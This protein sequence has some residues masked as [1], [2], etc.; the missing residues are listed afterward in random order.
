M[1]HPA[2][3]LVPLVLSS[4]LVISGVAKLRTSSSVVDVLAALGV[5]ARLGRRL[6]PALP[7][8]EIGAAVALVVAPKGRLVVVVAA[9]VGVLFLAYAVVIVRLWRH[10]GRVRCACFGSLSGGDVTG[11]T[12]VRNLLLAAGA[13]LVL[14]GATRGRSVAAELAAASAHTWTWLA[15]ATWA[16]GVAA[17]L[18]LRAAPSEDYAR[19]PIPRGELVTPSGQ[20]LT[21]GELASDQARLLIFL[22]PGCGPC[23]DIS[24]MVQSWSKRLWPIV[25]HPVLIDTAAA[26]SEYAHLTPWWLFADGADTAAPALGIGATPAAVVLG[27]D[28]FLAGGPVAGSAAVCALVEEAAAAVAR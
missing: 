25:V 15:A 19:A 11:V 10:Q 16:T 6:D 27:S 20:H 18:G 7:W 24:M 14:L 3:L 26:R 1:S 5:P 12:V 9:L 2:W 8:I 21:L 13:V 17:S 23:H 28:G 22:S 4:V